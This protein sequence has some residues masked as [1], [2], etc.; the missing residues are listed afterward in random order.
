VHL[1]AD[2]SSNRPSGKGKM[3]VLVI[4]TAAFAAG[5]VASG[6]N[7]TRPEKEPLP[8][9]K[10]APER[11]ADAVMVTVE[12][13][14]LQAI[15]RAV[16]ALGTLH[17][18]EEVTISTKVEG[19]V[20]HI[21]HDVADLLKPGELLLEIDSTD[22]ELAIRQAELT[23][24]VELAKLG[25][26]KLPDADVDLHKLPSVMQAQSRMDNAKSRF[27]RVK[28][29]AAAKA[30]SVEDYE[31]AANDSRVSQAEFANQ[32]LVAE[33]GLALIK[34]KHA[35]LAIA[36][37][38][39]QDC[40]VF[41]PTPRLSVPGGKTA[42]Y[43]VTQRAVAEGT[44]VRTGMELCKLV[45]NSTL[46]LRVLVPE[47]F[48]AEV[49]TGQ[50]AAVYTAVSPSPY[51]GVVA[52]ISP[53]VDPSTRTF[54]VEIL[55][56]N[57]NGELKSGSFAKASILTRTDSAAITVPLTS[58]VQFAGITKLFLVENGRAKEIQVSTGMQTTVWVE[59]TTPHLPAGAS[60]VTSGHAILASDT[61]VAIRSSA[62]PK[63]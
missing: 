53:A 42:Q 31:N 23:L 36:R 14:R 3:I 26:Q 49:K 19:R 40:K 10:I 2:E 20:R 27:D 28:N 35:A 51:D 39:F 47:R 15:Q 13:V 63:N 8:P 56:P 32:L 58:L 4:V 5:W 50:K 1:K 24:D 45:I 29:L 38:Q 18:F 21:H 30:S 54:L 9:D 48:S 22:Y 16:E 52:R 37:Q 44:F 59:I 33:T 57:P 46:K 41:A 34:M 7:M 25:L 60:V 17:A 55:V 62:V 12:P 61:P 11:G 43:A 6:W